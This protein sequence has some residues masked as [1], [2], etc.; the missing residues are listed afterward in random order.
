MQKDLGGTVTVDSTYAIRG[1]TPQNIPL[2]QYP[3][4]NCFQH[5]T[6]ISGSATFADSTDSASTITIAGDVTVRAVFPTRPVVAITDAWD[7]LTYADSA[8]GTRGGLLFSFTAPATDSFLV[9]IESVSSHYKLIFY[10]DTI[11]SCSSHVN[12]Y[13]TTGTRYF[14]FS[15]NAGD[16]YHYRVMPRYTDDTLEAMRI[17]YY[18][19]YNLKILTELAG[20]VTDDT[21]DVTIR[22]NDTTRIDTTGVPGRYY[23][24][25]WEVV[26]GTATITD[27]TQLNTSIVVQSNVVVKAVYLERPVIPLGF[28]W[29]TIAYTDYAGGTKGG[30]L[31]SFESNSNDSF[32]VALSRYP[33]PYHNKWLLYHGPDASCSTIVWSDRYTYELEYPFS[34]TTADPT[35]YF[36]VQPYYASDTTDSISIRIFRFCKVVLTADHGD[37][38]P[39]DTTIV[40]EGGS[41]QINTWPYPTSFYFVNWQVMAGSAVFDNDSIQ[42]TTLTVD[43]A[44]VW[45]QAFYQPKTL[46][47]ITA[48]DSTYSFGT[49]GGSNYSGGVIM[50]F[51]AP[52]A[53]SFAVVI[54]EAI[55]SVNK[56]LYYYGTSNAFTTHLDSVVGYSFYYILGAANVGET[57]YFR[58]TSES[59]SQAC[60]PYDYQ[61][62]YENIYYINFTASTGGIVSPAGP[63]AVPDSFP[64][65]DTARPA[66]AIYYFDR[67]LTVSGSVAYFSGDSADSIISV[68]PVGGDAFMRADFIQKTIHTISN[69][70]TTLTFN[71][72]GFPKGGVLM[73]YTAAR[74][75]SHALVINLPSSYAYHIDFFDTIS[76][77]TT[78]VDSAHYI[79]SSPY[80][81]K[82]VADS[83]GATYYFRVNPTDY[84][85]Y[86]QSFN[87]RVDTTVL[88]RITR[89][90]TGTTKP[91]DSIRF[92]KGGTITI[93][94]QPVSPEYRFKV[95]RPLFGDPVIADTTSPSTT[96]TL[97][98]SSNIHALFEVKPVQQIGFAIDTFCYAAEGAPDNSGGILMRFVSP[99]ADSFVISF[100]PVGYNRNFNYYYYG[101]DARFIGVQRE[102][103][104]RGETSRIGFRASAAGQAHYFR[105]NPT[106]ASYYGDSIGVRVLGFSTLILLTDGGGFTTPKDSATILQTVP[107][108]I[109]AEPISDFYQF[110]RWTVLNGDVLIGDTL[111]A[112]TTATILDTNNA[113]IQARFS[114]YTT[115]VIPKA[116]SKAFYNYDAAVPPGIFCKFTSEKADSFVLYVKHYNASVQK[117]IYF[118]GTDAHYSQASL[119]QTYSVTGL[120]DTLF[121]FKASAANTNHYFKIYPINS[122]SDSLS[123]MWIPYVTSRV[124]SDNGGIIEYPLNP[125]SKIAG[126]TVRISTRPKDS[127]YVFKNWTVTGGQATIQ[128]S[129]SRTTFVTTRVTGDATVRALYY[130]K[131]HDTLFIEDDTNGITVPLGMVFVDTTKD[132]SVAAYPNS[133]FL[134]DRW[135][136]V[137]GSPQI[138]DSA[139]TKMRIKL[140]GTTRIKAHF[141]PDPNAKPSLVINSISYPNHPEID[142]IATLRDRSGRVVP[143]EDSVEFFLM[144][145]ST[146][147]KITASNLSGVRG[148]SVSMVID[149]SESMA[150]NA[151]LDSALAAANTFVDAM[152]TYDRA[153]VITFADGAILDQSITGDKTL[154]KNALGQVR[155]VNQGKTSILDGAYAGVLQ[156]KG[157]SNVRAV[158]IFSDGDENA[159]RVAT[160]RMVIDTARKYDVSIYS[161]AVGAEAFAKVDSTL[162]PLADSTYGYFFFARTASELSELYRRI[163]ADIQSRYLI[164]YVSPDKVIDGDTHYVYLST[165][166]SG[167]LVSDTKPWIEEG[168]PPQIIIPEATAGL[169]QNSQFSGVALRLNFQI[170][171]EDMPVPVSKLSYRLVGT[172]GAWVEVNLVHVSGYN[173]Y[174]DI[175]GS[176][177]QKP[178]I[179]YKVFAADRQGLTDEEGPFQINVDNSGPVI[180]HTPPAMLYAFKNVTLTAVVTDSNSV[181]ELLIH[182]KNATAAGFIVDTM[183]RTVG[184]TFT[185]TIDGKYLVDEYIEYYLEARDAY[186]AMSRNPVA[187]NYKVNVDQP[188]RVLFNGSKTWNEGDSVHGEFIATDPEGFPVKL[189]RLSD[190]PKG[191]FCDSA[192]PS[193][194]RLRWRT[195]PTSHGEYGFIF[196]TADSSYTVTDTIFIRINDIDF[197]PVVNA[198]NVVSG[199]EGRKIEFRIS[200]YD[201]DGN[202]VQFS[203]ITVPAGAQFKDNGNDTALFTWATGSND[204]GVHPLVYTVSDGTNVLRDTVSI[205]IADSSFYAPVLHATTI[206]TIIPTGKTIRIS[207]WATDE[208]K[209]IPSMT[210]TGLPS[211]A[212]FVKDAEGDSGVFAWTAVD[213]DEVVL[214]ATAF[215]KIDANQSDTLV[216]TITRAQYL[217]AA[218]LQDTNANGFLDRVFFSWVGDA[219]LKDSLPQPGE[220]ID[221]L[222]LILSD[223]S[224][225]TLD[226]ISLDFIDSMHLRVPLRE[227]TAALHTGYD[228]AIVSV[229][230]YA[231]TRKALPTVITEV[232]DRAGPV[233]K[234]AVYYPG[235]QEAGE[236]RKIVVHLSEPVLWQHVESRPRDFLYY[237]R[238]SKLDTTLFEPL[239]AVS[240]RYPD[241][242]VVVLPYDTKIDV[243]TD[244][245][246]LRQVAS[247]GRSHITDSTVWRTLPDPKNRRVPLRIGSGPVYIVAEVFDTNGQGTIDKINL[248]IPPEYEFPAAL[249]S[250]DSVVNAA[251]VTP[252]LTGSPRALNI[253]RVVKGF[254]SHELSIIVAENP[255]AT[256]TETGWSAFSI[257]LSPYFVSREKLSFKLAAIR[258]SVGPVIEKAVVHTVPVGVVATFDTLLVTFSEPVVWQRNNPSP[259]NVLQFFTGRRANRGDPFAGLSSKAVA[260]SDS[261]GI[262]IVMDNGFKFFE[263]SDSLAIRVGKDGST[264][265]LN[266]RFGVRPHMNNRKTK[267]VLIVG[268]DALVCPNPFVPGV[269]VDPL[270]GKTGVLLILQCTSV[271][272]EY[273]SKVTIFNALGSEVLPEKRMQVSSQNEHWLTYRW[274]G[275]DKSGRYVGNGVYLAKFTKRNLKTGQKEKDEYKKVGVRR[276]P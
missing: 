272:A 34:T 5:W 62:R 234:R 50:S 184:D 65:P 251:S 41:M 248:V 205:S 208:D 66:S 32:V 97:S 268:P 263:G 82:F 15:A 158:I 147:P 129:L 24:D 13:T 271:A 80:G 45:A 77:F 270:S 27:S 177:V 39:S 16:I 100:Y 116:P 85:D 7:T 125:V 228:S 64:I 99:R 230:G 174:A 48:F 10:Y 18:Q 188:P 239:P 90:S 163:K 72:H 261:F 257:E 197:P 180:L 44:D 2:P 123:I 187:T 199:T 119:V 109:S 194:M 140:E 191:A 172:A 29:D 104:N 245:L 126:D 84:N 164:R 46:Y 57:H 237:Y 150:E 203:A 185:V 92:L 98:S 216:I 154:L 235:A 137:R 204:A 238:G 19:Y 241:S 213:Q 141:K 42:T 217:A 229:N 30:L 166:L 259:S 215:D 218:A 249:P 53:D 40:R 52:T 138:L 157:E 254:N 68:A 78:T 196:R 83:A 56:K 233:I 21:T 61:I 87:V 115:Y 231:V 31:F 226:P 160:L 202:V 36:R 47:P 88:L 179:E 69:S 253:R 20:T 101:S 1:G 224:T 212:T 143:G 37:A 264:C 236:T 269:S 243:Q 170:I 195:G 121:R 276:E 198:P 225:L 103:S 89:D 75:D 35:H 133:R 182:Y 175:P 193:T 206:D 252:V 219:R 168:Q 165:E 152:D 178:G 186:L 76:A 86:S 247:D 155:V 246:S 266:D 156:L 255:A 190:L 110:W 54:S 6:R 117:T 162:R 232:Q 26:S 17:R 221:T 120:S 67:W 200:A 63:V 169:S 111:M 130:M 122:Y 146:F 95:W 38:S 211:S 167:V 102:L 112:S 207:I 51:T 132:T 14:Y 118:F 107:F 149:R 4:K 153:A 11:A 273:E 81:F 192:N 22:S 176:S 106:S 210:V 43:S 124:E 242:V 33:S 227:K 173:Y 74:A 105:I 209:T 201:P 148:I 114:E 25:R 240:S 49:H 274:N 59:Y 127:L 8:G 136:I 9:Q 214:T 145:D 113:R 135:E 220:W 171:D 267:V 91:A 128:D 139:G 79:S 96:I 55:H 183:K 256:S 161:I 71:V 260:G 73:K 93:S 222:S 265:I 94:A 23:F 258:D 28:V 144:Q 262:S 58:V 3:G 151:R 142:V 244:S 275:K 189:V 159:S 108:P 181:A 250:T 134:F 70:D 223:G 131:P 12:L 60:D